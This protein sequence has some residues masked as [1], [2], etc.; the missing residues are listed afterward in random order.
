[1]K[2]A[3]LTQKARDIVELSAKR[4]PYYEDLTETQ[5]NNLTAA[6]MRDAGAYAYEFINESTFTDEIGA[7]LINYYEATDEETRKELKEK[8]AD[9][10]INGTME[11][12]K[13]IVSEALDE[14]VTS[15]AVIRQFPGDYDDYTAQ[16]MLEEDMES[17][18]R[19]LNNDRS[20]AR[21]EYFRWR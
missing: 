8:I 13:S 9:L 15:L 11:Y 4:N 10:L 16:R 20:D 14:A 3:T 21:S 17:R 5:R 1:M 19:D 2:P 18:A 7:T 6:A 12:G